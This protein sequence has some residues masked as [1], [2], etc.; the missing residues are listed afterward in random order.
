[1][2]TTQTHIKKTA[3]KNSHITLYQQKNMSK[4][5]VTSVPA[6]SWIPGQLEKKMLSFKMFSSGIGGTTYTL[7]ENTVL[8][9]EE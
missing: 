6:F 4:T 8:D 7:R 9:S 1:M 5:L 2:H 3:K